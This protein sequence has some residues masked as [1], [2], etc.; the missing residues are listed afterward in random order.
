MKETCEGVT[1][2]VL[3]S[4]ILVESR[5]CQSATDITTTRF[6]LSDEITFSIDFKMSEEMCPSFSFS[7]S[8]KH[9]RSSVLTYSE[10]LKGTGRIVGVILIAT[11]DVTTSM[12]WIKSE[13]RTAT[14][15]LTPSD[16]IPAS[17]EIIFSVEIR[18]SSTF[19]SS[20][21][22]EQSVRALVS[23]IIGQSCDSKESPI[24]NH[25]LALIYS[26]YLKETCQRVS[27]ALTASDITGSD[28][29][30]ESTQGRDTGK[31]GLSDGIC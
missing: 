7:S 8:E 5:S 25:L 24:N 20:Q 15:M 17:K 13:T 9:D 30:V 29:Y 28:R 21:N 31:I 26:E 1:A 6:D 19:Q 16:E 18:T 4:Q 27:A 10:C 3:S 11:D 22:F 2:A 23:E 12:L 14:T